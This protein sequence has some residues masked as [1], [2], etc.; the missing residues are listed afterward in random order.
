MGRKG[1]VNLSENIKVI[2]TN[3][4]AFH[5]YFIEDK[6]ECGIALTGT[7]IKSIRSG[8]VN[9]TEA[10]VHIRQNEVY[11]VGMHIAPY[12]QGNQFNHDETR[13][14]KLLLHRHQINRLNKEVSQKGFTLIPLRIYIKNGLAK[15]EIALAKGK[16][17]YDK[18]ESEKERDI[19]RDL[20]RQYKVR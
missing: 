13:T 4:K 20:Q 11:I 6:Y 14:R 1:D 10:Y 15:V 5:D 12:A 16:K 18:R 2:A 3:R 8:K 19:K 17:L 7:E 9:L